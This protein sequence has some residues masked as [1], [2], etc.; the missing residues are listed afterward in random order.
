[1]DYFCCENIKKKQIYFVF[2]THRGCLF[3]LRFRCLNL[4]IHLNVL[5][6]VSQSE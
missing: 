6:V 5:D 4:K 1:M 2:L 3:F